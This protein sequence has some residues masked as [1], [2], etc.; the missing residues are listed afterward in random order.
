MADSQAAATEVAVAG[1]AAA[2]VKAPE[3]DTPKPGEGGTSEYSGVQ[4]RTKESVLM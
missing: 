1:E 4:C 2:P 3:T